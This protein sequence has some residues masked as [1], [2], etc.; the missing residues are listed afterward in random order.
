MNR[1]QIKEQL[2]ELFP[3]LKEKEAQVLADMGEDISVLVTR[4][5]D[6]NIS[7]PEFYL[8]E[9]VRTN[10]PRTKISHSYNYPEVFRDKCTINM[11]IDVKGLRARAT[12]LNNEAYELTKKAIG[13]TIKGARYHF[14]IEAEAKR[15]LAKEIN[16]DAILVLMRKIVEDTGPVDLHGFTVEE[17][18]AFMDDLLYFKKFTEIQLITGQKYNSSRIRPAMQEWFE[19]N[20]F[21]CTEEGPCLL[22]KKKAFWLL[23]KDSRHRK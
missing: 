11:H 14:S 4:V 19:I 1:D 5:L 9:L 10:Y 18:I 7:P 13:H 20:K 21:M 17:A 22:G 15:K 8:N 2:K 23:E 6:N 16:R 3:H 12:L